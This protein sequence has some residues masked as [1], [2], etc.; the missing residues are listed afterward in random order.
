MARGS[1][2]QE[3]LKKNTKLK[4]SHSLTIRVPSAPLWVGVK[5]MMLDHFQGLNQIDTG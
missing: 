4:T 1:E 3:E 5:I 2:S